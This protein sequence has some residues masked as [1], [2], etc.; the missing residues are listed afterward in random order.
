[1][2]EPR[3]RSTF[4]PVLAG[5]LGG[6]IVLVVGSILIATD[7]IDTGDTERVVRQAP[8]TQPAGDGG[9]GSASDS[10]RGRTVQ[11]I[12]RTEGKGVVFVQ[13][14]GVSEE[15][16]PFGGSQQG[17]ATGS[18]FVVDDD[19]T[20]VTNAHV[21]EG[22][23][24]VSV[25]FG[26]GGNSVDADV[27]GVDRDSDTAVLKIDP[28]EVED[29]TVLPLG[30]SSAAEVGDPVIA[31]GNPF[32]FT[33]TVTTGIVSALQ[34]QI[35]APSGFSISDVIQTDA[36]IN[37]GNSGGPLLDADGRVIGINSQIATGGGSQGSVGIGFAVPVNLVKKLIPQLKRGQEIK[38]AYLGIKMA[39]V[40]SDVAKALDLPV[41]Q[42]ALI[43]EVT[44]GGPADKAGLRAGSRETDQ[45]LVEGGDL[46]VKVD[47][48]EVKQ[49]SD[50]IAALADNKPGDEIQLEYYRGGDKRTAEVTLGERPDDLDAQQPGSQ[51]P[52][53]EG[54]GPFPLP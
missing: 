34:R 47:G 50:V 45:G 17:T 32:G 27:R 26:E 41:D 54:E 2:N 19:G 39:D 38:R 30:N 49:A 5:I 24:S 20:I 7:V 8:I 52:D 51:S 9:E 16:S 37:P 28:N 40:T 46:L 18:G 21:V 23:S 33:R 42:G 3:Q 1:M 13:A 12:Y 43:Q 6:L 22:A 35:T 48:E 36:A 15:D 44:P 11:D 10:D 4:A 14:Q 29:L 25:R 53:D 31:I